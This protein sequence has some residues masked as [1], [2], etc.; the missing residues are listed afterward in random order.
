VLTWTVNDDA[1]F[2]RLSPVVDAVI[3]DRPAYFLGL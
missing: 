2:G 3:T 1:E